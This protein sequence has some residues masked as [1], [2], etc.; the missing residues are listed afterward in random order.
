MWMR[1]ISERSRGDG[2]DAIE[3]ELGAE[4]SNGVAAG[5]VEGRQSRPRAPRKTTLPAA[6]SA[7][8]R[9]ELEAELAALASP[10]ELVSWAA[11]TL[12]AKNALTA[13]DANALEAAF[14][15]HRQRIQ[16]ADSAKGTAKYHPSGP[17]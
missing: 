10:E 5:S 6:Q 15:L 7:K 11:R 14:E 17:P 9:S 13:A 3:Q 16:P 1:R 2:L 4:G 12:P 8:V